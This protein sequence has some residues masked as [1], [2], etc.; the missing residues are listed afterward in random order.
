MAQ[1][2]GIDEVKCSR[3]LIISAMLSP[4]TACWGNVGT[5]KTL[6]GPIMLSMV[7]FWVSI[8]N[9]I[10]VKPGC[11]WQF[12]MDECVRSMKVTVDSCNC[13]GTNYKQGGVMENNCLKWRMNPTGY[14][15]EDIIGI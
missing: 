13:K 9:S 15:P 4:M 12:D 8:L 5:S 7:F 1:D 3:A 14:L 10:E 6:T 11:E 2:S